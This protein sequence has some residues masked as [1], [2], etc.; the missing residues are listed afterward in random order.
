MCAL[1]PDAPVGVQQDIFGAMIFKAGSDERTEFPYQLFIAA[2][3]HLLKFLHSV[4]PMSGITPLK[5]A[6]L[7]AH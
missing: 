7:Y 2:C 6:L 4:L 1:H 3:G 5:L